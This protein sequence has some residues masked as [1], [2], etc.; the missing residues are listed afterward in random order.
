[1]GGGV[2]T[3]NSTHHTRQGGTGVL[4]FTVGWLKEVSPPNA[5]YLGEEEERRGVGVEK[6]GKNSKAEV[7]REDGIK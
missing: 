6:V 1:M 7:G 4:I 5:V 3:G 2:A